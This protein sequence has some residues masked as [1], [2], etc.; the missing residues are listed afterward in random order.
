MVYKHKETANAYQIR[1]RRKNPEKAKEIRLRSNMKTRD[2]T[3]RYNEYYK[4]KKPWVSLLLAAKRRCKKSGLIFE[5]TNE[6]GENS[7]TGF[8]GLTGFRFN[9]EYSDKPGWK[10]LS[11]SIDRIDNSKGYSPDNCRFILNCINCF[12]GSM[13]DR[14]MMEIAEALCNAFRK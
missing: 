4:Y 12:K 5:L 7:W 11:P 14:Q 9:L 1:W 3:K 13:T 2:T 10:Y 6:W 8:C